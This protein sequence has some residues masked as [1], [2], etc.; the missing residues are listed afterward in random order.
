MRK[1]IV[2]PILVCLLLL[3]CKSANP[4]A[5]PFRIM[6]FNIRFNTPNDG[7]N[8]WP[9]RRDR[10]ATT[11]RFHKAD[12]FGMQEVLL[13]QLQNL[14]ILFPEFAFFGV[15]RDDGDT[16]G[17]YCPVGYRRARFE[18]LEQETFWLSETPGQVSRGWDAACNRIVTWGRFRDRIT[19]K[20]FVVF[21][22]HF[23]HIGPEARRSA[24]SLLVKKIHHIAGDTPFILTGDFNATPESEPMNILL[25]EK[26]TPPLLNAK[27][28]S[29]EPHHGPTYTYTGFDPTIRVSG[30]PIDYILVHPNLSVLFHATLSDHDNG[31]LPSDHFPVIAEVIIH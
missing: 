8:A 28:L 25:S 29:R 10:V 12:L 19:Q 13:D 22:T 11:I 20:S 14:E 17:E 9:K 31:R 18:L 21:N 23:D 7:E 15:G 5:E 6:T 1:M 26:N 4:K 30:E 27:W 2:L 24:A 16:A 3:S